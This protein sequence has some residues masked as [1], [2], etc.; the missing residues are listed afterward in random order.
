[1][2]D[3]LKILLGLILLYYGGDFLVTGS[4]RLSRFFKL[5]TF[6]IG[7]TVIAFGTS[8]P[9]LAVA[10]LAALDAAPELA[11]GNVIGSNI[12]NIGLVLG[13]TAL[14]APLVISPKRLKHEY[15]PLFLATLIILL[16]AWDLNIHRSEGIIMLALLALY[17]WRSFNQKEDFETGQEEVGLFANK[18][19]SYQFVLVLFGLVGLISGA[20]FLVSGGVSIARM[21]GIS[22][23]FIGITIVAIG[24]SLPELV[25]S[26]MA[27]RRGQGEM[28]IGNIFGS[29][30]FN[31]LMVLGITSV[32]QPLNIQEPIHPD[33]N[34]AV[35]ITIL[36]LV[37]LLLGKYFLKKLGGIVLLLTYC[38]Y[39]TLKGIGL[40]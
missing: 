36:L 8:A 5:S 27:A 28:A 20:K 17:L 2:L 25:A 30:I 37:L 9:E 13:L 26:I 40:I 4:V 22:E 7:A 16:L 14:I 23:W 11:M 29:N 31:I 18:G 21:I 10:I 1:M 39:I 3:S 15:P 19:I 35:G 33:L 32:I 38:L 12:A 24:T 6:V 34:I